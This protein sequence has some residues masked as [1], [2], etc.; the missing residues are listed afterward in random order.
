MDMLV[1]YA[2]IIGGAAFALSGFLLGVRKHLDLMG[3]FIL[4]FITANGG[5][6]LRDVLVGMTPVVLKDLTAFWIVSSVFIFGWAL[7][8]LKRV[9]IERQRFFILSDTFGLVAFSIGGALVGLE[10]NLHFFGVIFLAFV[11][12]VGGGV[13]RDIL[14]NDV[15][16]IFK[17]GFYGSV[18]ILIGLSVYLLEYTGL[19]S[20]L[21]LAAIFVCGLLVRL[22]AYRYRW[23]LPVLK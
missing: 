20:S 19:L 16:I 6:I 17:S 21:S 7:H 8:Y 10:Q 9:D 4:A 22:V 11:T 12:A 18:A 1:S 3:I 14:V 13:I 5:G 23:T 15:P 2:S